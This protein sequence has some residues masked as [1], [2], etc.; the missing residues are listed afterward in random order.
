MATGW[1]VL[2]RISAYLALVLLPLLLVTIYN[3][4]PP[5][6]FAYNLGR[7][8]ALTAF[9]IM[10][11]QVGLAAR[12]K[13]VERPFG[14]NLTFP[15][16]R[17]MGLLAAMLL[18]T[19]PFLMVL[20]GGPYP[21]PARRGLGRKEGQG[22][23]GENQAALR[24]APGAKPVFSLLPAAHDAKSWEILRGLGVPETR[25]SLEYFSL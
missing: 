10:I 15:F 1:T 22:G 6:L 7:G 2:S 24:R 16:H 20:G 5:D 25:I 21:E 23:P 17:R 4:P 12:V 14:L 18:L 11:L 3:L 8:F 13:W 19:H 9:A